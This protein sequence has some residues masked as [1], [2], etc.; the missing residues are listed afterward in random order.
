[1][2]FYNTLHS[3]KPKHWLFNIFTY[4]LLP[5]RSYVINPHGLY[6]ALF[7]YG[8]VN[9]GSMDVQSSSQTPF[10]MYIQGPMT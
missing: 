10:Q 7:T 9:L 8:L 1:M 6:I 2:Q 5:T 4:I 3:S